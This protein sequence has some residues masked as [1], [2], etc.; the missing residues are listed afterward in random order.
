MFRDAAAL[1][2]DP[3]LRLSLFMVAMAGGST[4]SIGPY[5]SIV[6]VERLSMSDS[7]YSLLLT[8][9]SL[10]SMTVSV[11]IGV[12]S[13]QTGRRRAIV[14][15][16]I[17]VSIFAMALMS[18]LPST[19]AFVV[20]HMLLF[21]IGG[22]AFTQFFALGRMAASNNDA[23]HADTAMSMVRAGFSATF[24]I[25]PLFWGF[26]LAA[27]MDV[28]SVYKGAL[29]LNI[30]M[31]AACWFWWPT[32]S[33]AA[34]SARSGMALGAALKQLSHGGVVMRV[35][36]VSLILAANWISNITLGLII[37]TAAGGVEANVGPV[38]GAIALLEIPCMLFLAAPLQKRFSKSVLLAVASFIYGGY[39]AG[40]G[41]AG[42]L[43]AIHWLVAPAGIGLGIILPVGIGYTQDLVKDQP[44]AGSS[45]VAVTNFLATAM[46]AGFF[47]IGTTISDY[48]G[49]AMIG[50]AVACVGGVLLLAVDR[51]NILPVQPSA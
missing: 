20:V 24:A 18:A 9:A 41:L 16:T 2:R 39:L 45:L 33:N 23:I 37:L 6:G 47:A 19:W 28:L 51:L 7:T 4:A 26:A 31:F 49:T 12:A 38:F 3:M 27:G 5:M 11:L 1:W 8:A 17:G 13:D 30:I 35:L 21:P 44:G 46:A 32:G 36:I 42:S 22:T 48:S 25:A 34:Y 43:T 15:A 29:V 40:L 14:L 10:V 50:A